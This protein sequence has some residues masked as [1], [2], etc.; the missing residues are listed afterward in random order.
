MQNKRIEEIEELEEAEINRRAILAQKAKRLLDDPFL[1]EFFATQEVETLEAMKR[2]PMGSS[3]EVYQT[4]HHDLL[5]C[6]KL[7]KR[8]EAYITDFESSEIQERLRISDVDG[9]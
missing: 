7:K 8:L 5:S 9:I 2:L 1:Q 6:I 4:I 3:L